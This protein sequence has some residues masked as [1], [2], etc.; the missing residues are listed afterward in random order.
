MATP[1]Q[2]PRGRQGGKEEIRASVLKTYLLRVRAEKGDRAVATLL[3]SSSNSGAQAV[4][5]R[6]MI[7]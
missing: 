1:S 5:G 2:M 7:S 3:A 4:P 6:P